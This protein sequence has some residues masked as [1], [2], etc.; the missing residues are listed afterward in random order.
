MTVRALHRESGQWANVLDADFPSAEDGSYASSQPD[1]F[2][3][4]G[5]GW[6]SAWEVSFTIDTGEQ[7]Q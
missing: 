4:E 2:L 7:A 6:V 1:A 3:L 5:V